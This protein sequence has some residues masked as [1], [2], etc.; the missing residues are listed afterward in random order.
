MH[1]FLVVL[2]RGINVTKTV[3]VSELRIVVEASDTLQAL[4]KAELEYL[5][6]YA[7]K[8]TQKHQ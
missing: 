3:V 4:R 2:E 5:G 8:A 6:W 7:T 1:K